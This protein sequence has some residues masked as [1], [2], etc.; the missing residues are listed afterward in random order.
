MPW[1]TTLRA[2]S[3][4]RASARNGLARVV[5]PDLSGVSPALLVFPEFDPLLDEGLAYGQ[6][7]RRS[8]VEVDGR[9]GM[10]H[11][12]LRMVGVTAEAA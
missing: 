8:D 10:T 12:F 11:D 6:R 1:A 3:M 9:P 2:C 5:L 4:G 7:L